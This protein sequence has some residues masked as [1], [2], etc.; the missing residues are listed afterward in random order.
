VYAQLLKEL[1]ILR[2]ALRTKLS[3]YSEVLKCFATME[4]M[5]QEMESGE[6]LA[7]PR[8]AL[9]HKWRLEVGVPTFVTGDRDLEHTTN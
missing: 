6:A 3:K 7:F 4:M 8:Q 5:L 1:G 9:G 2:T